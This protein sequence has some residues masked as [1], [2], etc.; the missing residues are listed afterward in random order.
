MQNLLPGKWVDVFNYFDDKLVSET[1]V[2]GDENV[3]K[4][5]LSIYIFEDLLR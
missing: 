1:T 4:I 3:L 5:N 2:N